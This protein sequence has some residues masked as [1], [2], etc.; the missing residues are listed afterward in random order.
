MNEVSGNN[1]ANAVQILH[2]QFLNFS[3]CKQ[4]QTFLS[5]DSHLVMPSA[6][7]FLSQTTSKICTHPASFLVLTH[8]F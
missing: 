8:N 3:C 5:V 6:Q 1:A 4:N 7:I 2:W